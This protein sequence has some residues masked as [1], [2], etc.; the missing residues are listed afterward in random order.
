MSTLLALDAA[1]H[2]VYADQVLTQDDPVPDVD[3]GVYSKYGG[4]DQEKLN[5]EV[6]AE[7]SEKDK[8]HLLM[9]DCRHAMFKNLAALEYT[10]LDEE[11]LKKHVRYIIDF[12]DYFKDDDPSNFPYRK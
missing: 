7:L 9:D 12:W 2:F 6:P 11:R 5:L 1:K 10:N 8:M 4:L 3:K